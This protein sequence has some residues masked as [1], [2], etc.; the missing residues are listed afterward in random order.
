MSAIVDV[1][2][3]QILDSRGNP[4]VEAEI[5]L[6]S[7]AVGRAGVPSGASTGEQEAVELRDGGPRFGGKG[8]T[9]AVRNVETELL[10]AVLGL[11]ARDQR[12]NDRV[13]IDTD[14]TA[15]K[16]RLGANALL[17]VSLATAH[18]A[19]SEV[20][21]PLYRYLGGAG[22]NILPVPQMNL[23]NGGAHAMGGLDFQECMLLPVG[24]ERFSEALRCGAEVF[25]ALGRVLAGAGHT[26][27]VGD[28]GGFAPRLASNRAAFETLVQAIE[29]AGYQ[30]GKD[31]LLGV[32]LAAS[33]LLEGGAYRLRGEDR[34]LSGRELEELVAELARDFPLVSVEDALGEND[35]EGWRG[36][37]ERLGESLQI[38]GDDLFVTRTDLLGRGIREGV[39]NSILIK[40]N[41]V[42]T[43]SETLDTVELAKKAGYAPVVS[44]R[45]GETED[46]TIADLAVAVGAGQ[47]KTGSVSRSE[48]VAKYNRLLRIEEELG[49]EARFLGTT[50]LSRRLQ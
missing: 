36:L 22:A 4:T 9:Q 20:G 47:I 44:H 33:E 14:G 11:E 10:E 39:A 46:N 35:W 12:A 40:P 41:Q 17:A 5:W 23:I 15:N 42:G 7:G 30:P 50:A 19:A 27:G 31:V 25:H 2:G 3:R 38:V 8:V 6:E 18:A 48:R 21:L 16:G 28:E 45:S 37:T 49:S 43:L 24:F 34:S 29:E 13:L 26:L 1:R 32:D